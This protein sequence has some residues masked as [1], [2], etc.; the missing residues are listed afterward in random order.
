MVFLSATLSDVK[1]LT[2]RVTL[3]QFVLFWIFLL[4]HHNICSNEKKKKVVLVV[5]GKMVTQQQ[6]QQQQDMR[7]YRLGIK[8]KHRT[9]TCP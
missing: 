8:Q 3:L 5:V 7:V 9:K 4:L 6:Q 2:V 1:E